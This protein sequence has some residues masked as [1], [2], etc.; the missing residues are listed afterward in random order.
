M[1]MAESGGPS[2][3]SCKTPCYDDATAPT[4]KYGIMV[5]IGPW[6]DNPFGQ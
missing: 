2:L 4:N 5:Y 3:N 6:K 1:P